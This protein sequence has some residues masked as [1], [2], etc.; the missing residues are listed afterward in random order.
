MVDADAFNDAGI[1]FPAVWTDP[2]F[3]GVLE[4]GTP[5][6]Q[7][8]AVPRGRPELVF[9]TLKDERATRYSATIAEVLAAP[10]VY[11]KRFRQRK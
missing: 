4:K 10:N 3:S 11:R 5:I 8:F 9:D 7:C 6:A 2:G 1:N